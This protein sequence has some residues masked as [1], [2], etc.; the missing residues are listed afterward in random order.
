MIGGGG[1]NAVIDCGDGAYIEQGPP[2]PQPVAPSATG[3][4]YQGTDGR[5]YWT[6]RP[7]AP[8]APVRP[9][10]P[11]G[12]I[13]RSSPPRSAVLLGAKCWTATAWADATP[14]TCP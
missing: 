13:M 2:T 5:R 7:P 14:Q 6:P 4:Y 1:G 10:A 11:S 3:S 9:P 12:P 8:E